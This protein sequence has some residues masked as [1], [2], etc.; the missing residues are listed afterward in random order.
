MN[1]HTYWAIEQTTYDHGDYPFFLGVNDDNDVVIGKSNRH[2]SLRVNGPNITI[3]NNDGEIT[4]H[5]VAGKTDDGK[6]TI[7]PLSEQNTSKYLYWFIWFGKKDHTELLWAILSLIK[8]G[9]T[10]DIVVLTDREKPFDLEAYPQIRFLNVVQQVKSKLNRVIMSRLNIFCVKPLIR[11]FVDVSVYDWMIYSDCDIVCTQPR[12]MT[13]FGSMTDKSAIYYSQDAGFPGLE[14]MV[15]AGTGILTEDEIEKNRNFSVNAGWIMIP[16]NEV[17]YSLLDAWSSMEASG[18]YDIDDQGCLYAL[19]IRGS[20]NKIRALGA[21]CA[22][23]GYRD[24]PHHSESQIVHCY[25]HERYLQKE[26][27]KRIEI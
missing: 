1:L 27:I 24:S 14:G 13:L 17:G 4:L 16:C 8:A 3:L 6:Y 21:K 9:Y 12:I 20:W 11:D 2:A 15:C 7:R 26:L 25:G 19:L 10:G 22:R 18:D 23:M 5:F